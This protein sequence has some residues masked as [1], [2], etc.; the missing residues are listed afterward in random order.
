MHTIGEVMEELTPGLGPIQQ[1]NAPQDIPQKVDKA[2]SSNKASNVVNQ[3]LTAAPTPD[4]AKPLHVK[5]KTLSSEAKESSHSNIIGIAHFKSINEVKESPEE[6]LSHLPA[7]SPITP[8]PTLQTEIKATYRSLSTSLIK[9]AKPPAMQKPAAAIPN[10]KQPLALERQELVSQALKYVKTSGDNCQKLINAHELNN[11]VAID[12]DD[13]SD[14]EAELTTNQDSTQVVQELIDPFISRAEGISKEVCS[15]LRELDALPEQKRMLQT[16]ID[17]LTTQIGALKTKIQTQKS[18]S[19][20][21]VGV[22]AEYSPPTDDEKQLKDL[23][24]KQRISIRNMTLLNVKLEQELPREIQTLTSILTELN[25]PS[26][27]VNHERADAECE[28]LA[29]ECL[30][31]SNPNILTYDCYVPTIDSSKKLTREER[32]ARMAEAAKPRS[33]PALQQAIQGLVNNSSRQPQP[34]EVYLKGNVPESIR[35]QRNEEDFTQINKDIGRSLHINGAKITTQAEMQQQLAQAIPNSNKQNAIKFAANQL[36]VTSMATVLAQSFPYV[37]EDSIQPTTM[38]TIRGTPAN[39]RDPQENALLQN[40]NKLIENLENYNVQI[41]E[42]GKTTVTSKM[43]FVLRQG[44]D[45]HLAQQNM[46]EV[47]FECSDLLNTDPNQIDTKLV[48][49]KKPLLKLPK[50]MHW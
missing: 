31:K 7:H 19:E 8:A 18:Q 41:E 50:G 1:T 14:D 12:S 4:M 47:Q 13:D 32:I 15:V 48:I 9:S 30:N 36:M 28:K 46:L 43:L 29:H 22:E 27:H 45:S 24:S 11:Q 3:A 10:L 42:S 40:A 16:E 6:R 44:K 20:E 26:N 25:T 21:T 33:S 5:A 35:N 34:I 37:N 49:T 23:I 39:P 2:L 17:N 38:K